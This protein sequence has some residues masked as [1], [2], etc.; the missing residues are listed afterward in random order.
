MDGQVQIAQGSQVIAAQ[1]VANAPLFEGTRVTTADDGRAEI[2]FDDGSVARISPNSS[3]T[4]TVLRGQGGAAETEVT[5]ESGLGYFE[6]R[7][8]RQSGQSGVRV[9]FGDSVVTSGGFTVLRVSMDDPPGALAVFSGN[10]HL[11]RGNAMAFDLHGGE[12]VA[13]SS[14]DPSHYDLAESIEPDSWDTWNSDRDQVLTAEGSSRTAATQ[15]FADS[16][17]PAWNDLDANG[18][19]YNV[20]GEGNVWSPNDA[21]DPG[22]DPY[23]S[24]YWM[25]TPL[26]GNVWLSG[27]S[28]G[29]LPYQCGMWNFY[30]NFGWGWAPGAGGCSPWWGAGFY[31]LNLGLIPPGYHPPFRPP[32]RPPR[33]PVG[34]AG[35][36]AI[37][38]HCWR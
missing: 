27:Y 1:A 31:G 17:N 23:G 28:W 32:V 11:E 9:G 15:G 3:L 29:Y 26:Y 7:G 35:R 30:D 19:W 22:F 2:Q 8:A 37:R 34:V 10:A 36:R 21:S 25:S 24:G 16:S 12:S 20:P 33:L 5:L 4:L 14:T 38:G 6:L 13:L 18:N